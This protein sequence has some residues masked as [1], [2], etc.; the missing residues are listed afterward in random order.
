MM[1]Y[2]FSFARTGLYYKYDTN[3]L[4]NLEDGV[5]EWF[6]KTFKQARFLIKRL[7]EYYECFSD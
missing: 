5:H 6:G 4:R 3:P 1:K 2:D 7:G